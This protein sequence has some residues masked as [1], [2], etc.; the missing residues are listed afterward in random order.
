MGNA[1]YGRAIHGEHLPPEVIQSFVLEKLRR[2][3]AL[4]LGDF[5]KVVI[6]VPAF[7]NEPRRKGTQDAGSLAGLE[8]LDIINEP[9]AAAIA[10]GVQEGFVTATGEA[11]EK[12]TIL[13]YD[14]GGGTF[15]VTLMEIDGK[16]YTAIATAGDVQL[17]GIDWDRRIVDYVAGVFAEKNGGLDPRNCPAGY[18]RLLREAEDAKRTL[19]ARDQTTITFEY[20][21]RIA[22]VPISRQQF[23]E[24]TADLLDRT[25]FTATNLIQDAGLT[26]VQLTRILLVGGLTRMPMVLRMLEEVSG[27]TPD[28]CLSADEA[29]AHGAAIYAGFLL[30]SQAGEPPKVTVRNVNSHDLG[31][32]G[33]EKSTERPRTRVMIPRNTPLPADRT[34]GF[35]THRDNQPS[36]V[37]RVVEGGDSSG[38]DA[39]HIGKCVVRDLPPGLPAG[40][41]VEVQFCYGDNGRLRVKARLPDLDKEAVSEIERVSGLTAETHR[42]WNQRLHFSDSVARLHPSESGTAL[43]RS[44]ARSLLELEEDEELPLPDTE[45]EEPP[46]LPKETLPTDEPPALPMT[47][48]GESPPLPEQDLPADEPPPLPPANEDEPLPLPKDQQESEPQQTSETLGSRLSD[49]AKGTLENVKKA[50]QLSA[51]VA[52]RTKLQTANLA[53]A[54]KALGRHIYEAGTHRD[55]LPEAHQEIDQLLQEVAEIEKR[56]A[57]TPEAKGM[58]DK[59]K[60]VAGTAKDKAQIQ[61]LKSKISG[62]MEKLGKAAFERDGKDSGPNELVQ[63]VVDCLARIEQLDEEIAE[64]SASRQGEV[65]TPKRIA[66]GAIAIVCLIGV[67]MLFSMGTHDEGSSSSNERTKPTSLR[68]MGPTHPAPDYSWNAAGVIAYERRIEGGSNCVAL[69]PDGTLMACGGQTIPVKLYD[70]MSCEEIAT[71]DA[72]TTSA[73]EQV[74]FSQNSKRIAWNTDEGVRIWSVPERR[75]IKTL[76][77]HLDSDGRRS[78]DTYASFS[79]DGKTIATASDRSDVVL[80][81]TTAW[82]QLKKLPGRHPAVFSPDGKLVAMNGTQSDAA[83]LWDLERDRPK[84][85]LRPA[86]SDDA[87]LRILSFTKEGKILVGLSDKSVLTFWDTETGDVKTRLPLGDSDFVADLAASKDGTFFAVA[88]GKRLNAAESILTVCDF[89][90]KHLAFLSGHKDTIDSISVSDD[91]RLLATLSSDDTVRLWKRYPDKSGRFPF[92]A[93]SQLFEDAGTAYDF[94]SID[95]DSIPEG[96][97]RETKFEKLD[98]PGQEM[99]GRWF[100]VPGYVR[101][102]GAFVRHGQVT[103]WKDSEKSA[104]LRQHFFYHDMLHG[105]QTDY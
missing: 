92:L 76:D 60:A 95:Y 66:I 61:L 36:I 68:D 41:P 88:G 58:A 100:E 49:A 50:G 69:S 39:T 17:G 90:T 86:D 46:P 14:L 79:P 77:L 3:A 11:R 21:G 34:A 74:V 2:D 23:E 22:R 73:T 62:R 71:L 31:V 65:L 91:G 48:V 59:A 47:E 28:R 15:D 6:S 105:L 78:V 8:V 29:V 57:D 4:W 99:H 93:A 18:Q 9:T 45:A 16:D 87:D 40:S 37:V 83:I 25:R 42:E 44:A 102:D 33:I 32:L 63:P 20:E 94:S 101:S 51:K 19:S 70:V 53:T 96:T 89:A 55:A 85:T 104:K 7:F 27:T 12:E 103:I 81:D 54:H 98:D 82:N 84:H 80:W 26:W 67:S 10:Y 72:E 38:N 5:C 97:K 30:D 52:E 1:A 43:N 64:L 24:M 56:I 75:I 13:I 35:A